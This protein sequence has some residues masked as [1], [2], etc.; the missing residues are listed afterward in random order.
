[1][2]QSCL[3]QS[4][5]GALPPP[6]PPLCL[7]FSFIPYSPGLCPWNRNCVSCSAQYLLSEISLSQCWFDFFFLKKKQ[8]NR[9]ELFIALIEYINILQMRWWFIFNAMRLGY[10][11][12]F[13][14]RIQWDSVQ[15]NEICCFY[16]PLSSSVQPLWHPG[17]QNW[18]SVS[19]SRTLR[20]V[21]CRV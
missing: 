4:S 12:C 2:R 21:E 15:C 7:F 8:C 18:S 19:C 17:E 1:M 9:L 5:K 14:C 3:K 20:H 11:R 6:P 13:I 16:P 10:W